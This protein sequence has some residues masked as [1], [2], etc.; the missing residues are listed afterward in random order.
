MDCIKVFVGYD[1]REAAGIWVFLQSLRESTRARVSVEFVGGEQGDSTNAFGPHERF[2]VPSKCGFRG[3]GI[4]VDGADMMMRC[5]L[6]QLI[7]TRDERHAV[8]VVKHDYLTQHRHKYIGTEMQAPNQD[9]P[10]K[11]WS[12]VMLFWNEHPACRRLTPEFVGAQ[13]GRFLHRFEWV[14]DADVGE[15]PAEW[16]WLADEYGYN[17][18]AKLVHWTAGIP[19]FQRVPRLAARR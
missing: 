7:E 19:G 3:W 11:N 15:L 10:R 1:A 2:L 9:Y 12:S 8:Q 5:D 18:A 14:D 13:S 16:N 6:A 4:F 17:A